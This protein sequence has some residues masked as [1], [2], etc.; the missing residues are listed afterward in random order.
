MELTASLL[1]LQVMSAS[2]G[3]FTLAPA[4]MV[5]QTRMS[6]EVFPSMVAWWLEA[7]ALQTQALYM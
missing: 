1:M 7:K 2:M 3:R 5:R 4:P 6:M